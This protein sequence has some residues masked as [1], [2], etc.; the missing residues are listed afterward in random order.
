MRHHQHQTNSVGQ[1]RVLFESWEHDILE[2]LEEGYS[3]AW[4]LA[5][6]GT[7]FLEG[8]PLL[9][10]EAAEYLQGNTRIWWEQTIFTQK[11]PQQPQ[12]GSERYIYSVLMDGQQVTETEMF[13]RVVLPL[14]AHLELGRLRDGAPFATS[15]GLFGFFSDTH[16]IGES[17]ETTVC[18]FQGC[19][20]PFII[21][22]GPEQYTLLGPCYLVPYISFKQR[23]PFEDLITLV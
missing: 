16:L 23:G 22:G 20:V 21:R 9:L 14:F 2:P 3:R 5:A 6:Y 10:E 15:N 18:L 8:E 1:A 12:N 7:R 4:I 19:N 11:E 17:L 13:K